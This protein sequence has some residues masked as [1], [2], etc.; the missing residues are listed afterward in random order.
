M[1]VVDNPYTD[2][3]PEAWI[4]D[5]NSNMR[6]AVDLYSRD[7]DNYPKEA[8]YSADRS[9]EP[10]MITKLTKAAA[11]ANWN[12][13]LQSEQQCEEEMNSILLELDLDGDITTIVPGGGAH[14]THDGRLNILIRDCGLHIV[15]K[16]T[17][18]L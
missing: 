4:T 15:E 16:S 13:S 12:H 17:F 7:I 14:V 18:F 6:S 8:Y 1:P 10:A 2:E 3:N 5:L 9:G 11:Y